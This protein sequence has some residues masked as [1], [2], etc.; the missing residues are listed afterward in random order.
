MTSTTGSSDTWN[1]GFESAWYLDIDTLRI[2]VEALTIVMSS[3]KTSSFSLSGIGYRPA[4]AEIPKII[5]LVV[6]ESERSRFAS[7]SGVRHRLQIRYG[8]LCSVPIPFPVPAPVRIR[9]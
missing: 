1:I 5:L 9:S 3:S 6:L 2:D 7:R 8:P 4:P